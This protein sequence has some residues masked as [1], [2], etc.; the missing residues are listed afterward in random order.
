M[1]LNITA[2]VTGGNEDGLLPDDAEHVLRLHDEWPGG[3]QVTALTTEELVAL[4]EVIGDRVAA[5][6][7]AGIW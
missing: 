5:T 1:T 2:T 3:T 4:Y 6:V 7:K